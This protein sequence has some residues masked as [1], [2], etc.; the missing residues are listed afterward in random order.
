MPGFLTS[1]LTKVAIT[2]I[3]TIVTTVLVRIWTAYANSRRASTPAF[4]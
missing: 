4:A 3:E 2:A 1:I